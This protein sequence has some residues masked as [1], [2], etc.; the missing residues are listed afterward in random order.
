MGNPI[1]TEAINP[2]LL[3]EGT[4]LISWVLWDSGMTVAEYAKHICS[5]KV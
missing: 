3:I 2:D 5:P 4:P 1:N